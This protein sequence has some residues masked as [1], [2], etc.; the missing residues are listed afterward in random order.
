MSLSAGPTLRSDDRDESTMNQGGWISRAFVRVVGLSIPCIALLAA[1][2]SPPASIWRAFSSGFEPGEA[3][4]ADR[5]ASGF[6]SGRS[7]RALRVGPP[8]VPVELGFRG[9]VDLSRP[10]AITLWMRPLEWRPPNATSDYVPILRV[11]GV[12][13]ATLVVERDR[14]HA[15]RTT[16]VWIA[17][18]F[19]L[20][21]RGEIQFQR[22]LPAFW[23]GEAWHFVAFQ[24]DATGF[25]L[26]LDDGPEARI[27]LPDA[28]LARD[29]PKAMST[30]L[31]GSGAPEGFLVDDLAVWSRSLSPSELA[32]LR[33]D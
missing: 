3:S 24:W 6:G 10:G 29:F 21:S 19:S 4:V 12:G 2:T 30:L 17:G 27:A 22:E 28:E 5:G 8:A 33:G 1:T 32:A 20:S 13:P 14:R 9:V 26:Q 15:G 18:F 23:S 31:I 25:A 11:A 7:G 16:D